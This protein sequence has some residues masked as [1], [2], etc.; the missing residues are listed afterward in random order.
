[1]NEPPRPCISLVGPVYNEVENIQAYYD[2][3]L[4]AIEGQDFDIE[5]IFVDDGS[6]DG[7]LALLRE[8][9][10]RDSRVRVFSFSRNFGAVA[11]CT[12]GLTHASG[13]AAVLMSV[14]LQDPPELIPE[15]V[16]QW[17]A[18]HDIVWA[19]RQTRD[20]PVAKR[21]IAAAFYRAI[22]FFVF[23]D[24]PKDGTDVGLFSRRVLDIFRALPERDSN[25]F[26]TLYSLGFDQ[27]RIPYHRG[28]RRAGVSG[29][30][31]WK[32][33]KN[34]VD[35]ITSFSRWPL[36]MISVSGIIIAGM[37]VLFSLHIIYRRVFLDL[38]GDGWPS[39][40]VLVAF[41]GGLQML[42]IGII[43]EYLWRIAEQT[44]HRPRYII[45]ERFSLEASPPLER[46]MLDLLDIDVSGE[47][48]GN[49]PES[50]STSE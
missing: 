45:S 8:L 48:M 40:A 26:F 34:A 5:F 28:K 10:S 4:A 23:P 42:F 29:W 49:R 47:A 19:V 13:D 22:R 6:R 12:C 11:A 18:G 33:A 30:P 36:R 46:P 35:I 27:A 2:E 38:G 31:F 7:S 25:P 3:V 32:R 16:A 20:D 43:A 39:L 50:G 21:L 15:F 1:M 9:A 37:S 41:L 44:R 24:Y 17:R 14:D